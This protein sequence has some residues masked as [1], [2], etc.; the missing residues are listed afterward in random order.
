MQGKCILETERLILREMTEEDIPALS[1]FLGDPEVMYAY[2]HGFDMEEVRDW[3]IRQ[4]KRY[5]KDGFGLWAVIRKSD[6]K[7]IGD[8][9]ITM[10][11][12][13]QGC[14]KEE[15]GYHLIKECWH[16]GYATEAAQAVK[17]YAFDV[18]GISEVCS[19][20]R[21]TNLASQKVAIRNGMKKCGESIRHYRGIDMPH[22]RY[23]VRKEP[24]ETIFLDL[25]GTLI[26]SEEGIIN[27]V[28]YALEKFGIQ[29][30]RKE[31]LAFIGPPLIESF[32][33][34]IG[35]SQEEAEKAVAYY[36]ENFSARGVYEYRLY[37][38]I[39][40]LLSALKQS[41]KK[42][43]MATSKPEHY[44]R[45]IAENAG[46]TGYFDLICGSTMDQTRVTKEDV[47]GYALE[48]CGLKKGDSSV[49]MLGD[50]KH[51]IL[52]AKAS[53]LASA[54]VLYGFGD[55]EELTKAGADYIFRTVEE[56]ENFLK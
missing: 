5:E 12:T 48:Q 37:D 19:I 55:M 25:D 50:R 45:I 49:V 14:M 10:Q 8:C 35:L 3:C 4:M 42:V 36:R 44:A 13:G 38:G 46:I 30:E 16:Q 39:K 32:R 28:V 22:Y 11:D 17:A 2:E 9:G 31:L 33:K 51:D 27:S 54:G 53:G 26:D 34:Y 41:G 21:D 23:A 52:G 7:L 43:V 47:I 24:Y 1:T 56:M 18:L 6:G 29:K 15:I 40:E 20:I